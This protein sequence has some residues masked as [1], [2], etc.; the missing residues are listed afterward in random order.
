MD[1]VS[2]GPGAEIQISTKG[3]YQ[4]G[5]DPTARKS[6]TSASMES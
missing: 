2:S 3:G 5:G 6:S 1:P 4:S